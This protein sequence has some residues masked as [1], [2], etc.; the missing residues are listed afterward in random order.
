MA[1]PPIGL[2]NNATMATHSKTGQ[3]AAPGSSGISSGILARV[4]LIQMTKVRL[5][6]IIGYGISEIVLSQIKVVR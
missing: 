4:E 1:P 3:I 5:D 6:L 2:S